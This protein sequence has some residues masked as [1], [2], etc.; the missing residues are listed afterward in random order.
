MQPSIFKKC[1]LLSV[2]A[3]TSCCSPGARG[4]RALRLEKECERCKYRMCPE[5]RLAHKDGCKPLKGWRM[6]GTVPDH[7]MPGGDSAYPQTPAPLGVPWSAAERA[8]IT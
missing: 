2:G 8:W 3:N 7:L 4:W 5:C 6:L 1:S